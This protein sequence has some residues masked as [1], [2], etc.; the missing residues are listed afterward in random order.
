MCAPLLAAIPLAATLGSALGTS[1]AAGGLIIAGVAAS[2]AAAAV[3]FKAQSD[4]VSSQNDYQKYQYE[5][6]QRLA[7]E[8]LL[9]Q[10]KQIGLRQGEERVA[11]SQQIQQIQR[12]G[13]AALGE[14][15]VQSAD[16]GVYGNSVDA[17][18][19][20]FRRQ[21]S[22]STSNAELN[23]LMRSRQINMEMKGMAG[24]AEGQV[25]RSMPQYAAD[26]S[27]LSPILQTMGGAFG[28]MGSL[29]GPGFRSTDGL[30]AAAAQSPSVSSR[31]GTT[32]FTARGSWGNSGASAGSSYTTPFMFPRA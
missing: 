21:Q 14:A 12:E 16:S 26:P 27:I 18:M 8:N 22:E 32:Q 5:Q 19:S 6:T 25:I 17:L 1:A 10:Y 4:A 13:Y 23:Y 7:N 15:A 2:G 3:S 20:D 30:G 28:M 11:M 31:F 29:A 9:L 24:Q